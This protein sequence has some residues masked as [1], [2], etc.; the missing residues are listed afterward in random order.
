MADA[1]VEMILRGRA[2][3]RQVAQEIANLDMKVVSALP[4][5]PDS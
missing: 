3:R 5:T 1:I 4:L 2:Q